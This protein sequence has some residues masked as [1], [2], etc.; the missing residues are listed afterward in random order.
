M[1]DILRFPAN[2]K[3]D[4]IEEGE[5]NLAPSRFFLDMKYK[6]VQRK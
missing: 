2:V 1:L 5:A 3:L 6:Q 4:L